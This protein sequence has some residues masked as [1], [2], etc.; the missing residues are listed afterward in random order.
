[1]LIVLQTTTVPFVDDIGLNISDDPRQVTAVIGSSV[2]PDV[3]P[4]G[5]RSSSATDGASL[6][7]C[8]ILVPDHLESHSTDT[9][10]KEGR[11]G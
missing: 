7:S 9:R 3:I 2:L 11:V 8:N 5:L 1:M 10:V 4:T 6:Y